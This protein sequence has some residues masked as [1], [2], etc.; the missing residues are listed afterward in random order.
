MCTRA[1]VSPRHNYIHVM[2]C[3]HGTLSRHC[4]LEGP[5]YVA[6]SRPL[7]VLLWLLLGSVLCAECDA[8]SD[9]EVNPS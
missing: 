8:A 3:V 6:A 5:A 4:P 2:V 9:A 1:R 7:S